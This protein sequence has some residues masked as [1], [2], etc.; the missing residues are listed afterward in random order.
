MPK[1][2][3]PTAGPESRGRMCLQAAPGQAFAP[4]HGVAAEAIQAGKTLPRVGRR[5]ETHVGILPG[6]DASALA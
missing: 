2:N 3:P 6:A 5:Q 4:C 1:T